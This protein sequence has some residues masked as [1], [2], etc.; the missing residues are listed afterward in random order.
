MERLEI[1]L[2]Q[3]AGNGTGR[4]P[5]GESVVVIVIN[6]LTEVTFAIKADKWTDFAS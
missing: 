5:S 3:M 4:S 6:E 1:V 2:Q